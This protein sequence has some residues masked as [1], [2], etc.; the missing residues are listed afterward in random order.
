VGPARRG[1]ASTSGTPASPRQCHDRSRRTAAR[2]EPALLSGE[3]AGGFMIVSTNP[4]SLFTP[5]HDAARTGLTAIV[6]NQ[7]REDRAS[8]ILMTRRLVSRPPTTIAPG[9]LFPQVKM[10]RPPGARTRNPRIERGRTPTTPLAACGSA[11]AQLAG[12][13]CNCLGGRQFA[14]QPRV[15]TDRMSLI[16]DRSRPSSISGVQ[17]M[18]DRPHRGGTGHRRLPAGRAAARPPA[19]PSESPHLPAGAPRDA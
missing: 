11:A 4:T 15:T 17:Q 12:P 14:T 8:A 5:V 6:A 10:G 18:H 2:Q 16:E 9:H 1:G 7:S 19:P 3:L 13:R